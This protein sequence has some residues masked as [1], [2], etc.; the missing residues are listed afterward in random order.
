MREEPAV[1]GPAKSLVGILTQPVAG[2][3]R[4][5]EIGVLLLNAGILHRVGP[6]RL[7]V[8]IARE[9]ALLGFTSF[10]FDF[11]GI[12]DSK[13]RKDNLPFEKSSIDETQSALTFVQGKCATDAFILLGG[14][15]GAR[16]SFATAACDPRVAGCI[17]INFQVTP[18]HERDAGAASSARRDERYYLKLAVRN[19]HSWVRLFTGQADYR[20]LS[21]A[22]ASALRRRIASQNT[23]A[24]PPQWATFRDELRRVIA[25]GVKPVFVCS[26]GDSSLD[27]LRD[28]GGPE[29]AEFCSQNKMKLVV[30][31]RSDHTFSSLADQE[32]LIT[33]VR[34]AIS[35]IVKS[36]PARETPPPFTADKVLHV[37]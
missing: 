21:A 25:R 31:P 30:V 6:G 26:E 23:S 36:A 33:V 20:K 12:G 32:R 22:L 15:S 29:M 35:E 24:E 3:S 37:Q 34:K 4:P 10:R 11:S 17:L 1:F 7:Y 13:P 18:D 14:C 5:E 28:A 8:K 27:E 2:N 19:S 9:L 16:V